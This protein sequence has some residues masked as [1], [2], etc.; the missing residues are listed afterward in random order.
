M[1]EEQTN[2]PAEEAPAEENPAAEEAKEEL[3]DFPDDSA[4][5]LPFDWIPPKRRNPNSLL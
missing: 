2:E 3:S 5:D 4:D 1:V